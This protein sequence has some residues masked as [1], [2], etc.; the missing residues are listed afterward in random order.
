MPRCGCH[1]NPARKSSGRS[2]RKSSNSRNGSNSWV[3]P[4]PNARRSLT[5]A[6]SM[7]G[8]ASTMRLIGRI[9]IETPYLRYDAGVLH[10]IHPGKRA[11]EIGVPFGLNLSLIG[12][13]SARR[14]FAV[15]RV[16]LVDDIH[17]FDHLPEG[18]EALRVERVIGAEVDEHLCRARAGARRRV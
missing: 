15:A 7:V 4:K 9:D 16:Q 17:P 11:F 1:G 13:P 18:R 14:A 10:I 6:P 2:L 5:P 12:P 3:L 8:L